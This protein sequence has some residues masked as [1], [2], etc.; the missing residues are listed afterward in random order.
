MYYRIY[1]NYGVPQILQSDNGKEIKNKLVD[2]FLL[3]K[4]VK[5]YLNGVRHPQTNG[6]IERNH[7]EI[8][9]YLINIDKTGN[10]N[11]KNFNREITNATDLYNFKTKKAKEYLPNEIK[12]II[13]AML[14]NEIYEIILKSM[15]RNINKIQTVLQKETEL[16]MKD[17][18]IINS[19][20]FILNK[21][22]KS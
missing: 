17:K 11:D 8:K 15:K 6:S 9:K 7:R 5:H 1:S 21:S 3:S 10:L 16:L 19:R 12:H 18:Y 14:K 4:S 13:D 20:I 22:A 2:E